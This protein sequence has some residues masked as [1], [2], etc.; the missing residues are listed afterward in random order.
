MRLRRRKTPWGQIGLHTFFIILSL[1]YILPIAL[2][3]G[4]SF[5]G[6]PNQYFSIIPQEF[7][8]RA[9]EMVFKNPDQIFQ[10]FGVTT[11]YSFVGV[12]SSLM[13]MLM[14]AYALS[15]RYFKLRGFLTFLLFFT[16]LFGGGM[17]GH[18]IVNASVLHINNTIW[19]YILPGVCNAWNII[20]IRTYIQGLPD[21]LFEAARLD[22]ASELRICF[23][24]VLPLSTPVLASVGF[25]R[26]IAAWN[27][28]N[29][30]QIYIRKPEL[31]SLQ[32]L[33]KRLLDN[34]ENLETMIE[35]GK[36]FEGIE[37]LLVNSEAMRFAMA[38]IVAVPVLFVFPFFQK[39][40]SK[41]M[42]IGS[43]KG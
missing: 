41:G 43:V 2:L 33:L 4:V 26:F 39:Y 11:F 13:V 25:L 6:S 34:I 27:N 9:Y 8:L 14:F 23:G 22:G 20:V 18:Y 35:R 10:A 5:E 38:V 15:R 21:E 19:V 3:I 29:T 40:F 28:W 37:E 31:Y 17:V 32:F 42:T 12:G 30:S 1:C 16:T 36:D 7:S 24:I